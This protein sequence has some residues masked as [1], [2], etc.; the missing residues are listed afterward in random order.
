MN[1]PATRISACFQRAQNTVAREQN[2][3]RSQIGQAQTA[4]AKKKA[5]LKTNAN[6]MLSSNVAKYEEAMT[7]LT[8]MN[9]PLDTSKCKNAT[10]DVQVSCLQDL[11]N[12][13]EALLHGS[14][15]QSTVTMSLTGTDPGTN[16][17]FQF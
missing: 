13:M 11:Q 5:D 17:T 9:M 10:P 16:L 3:V 1:T 2:M 7:A 15:K 14:A 8:G 6:Q 12:N 4:L